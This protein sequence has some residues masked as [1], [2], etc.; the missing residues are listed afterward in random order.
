MTPFLISAGSRSGSADPRPDG[1]YT[2]SPFRLPRSGCQV[3]CQLPGQAPEP[4]QK[5]AVGT[6]QLLW[7]TD[8]F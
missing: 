5:A 4:L 3:D 8:G 2:N 6:K 7:E 1:G